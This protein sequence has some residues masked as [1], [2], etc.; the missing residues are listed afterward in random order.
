MLSLCD[1]SGIMGQPWR[2]AGYRTVQVDPLLADGA[3]GYACKLEDCLPEIHALCDSGSVAFV[4]AFPPCTDLASSGARWWRAK[5]KKDPLF[6]KKAADFAKLCASIGE[7]SGAPWFVENPVGRLSSLWR[8]PDHWFNPCDFTAYCPSDNYTKKTGL[9]AGGGF[10]MPLP[11]RVAS[12]P[13]PDSRIHRHPGGAGRARFRSKT[14][15][16]FARAVFVA[17][18]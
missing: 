16:G 11:K 13:K 10:V 18:A 6:Q 14:P 1:E 15:S 7:R 12:L 5:A 3:D 9:W 2:L 17:N 8:R 4:A